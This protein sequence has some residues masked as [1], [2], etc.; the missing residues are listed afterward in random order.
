[1]IGAGDRWG[2]DHSKVYVGETL[3]LER[4]ILYVA[5]FTLRLHKFHRGDDDRASHTHPWWFITFPLSPYRE[6]VFRCGM[7]LGLRVVRAW[8]PHFRPADFE[9]I[10]EGG[11][12]W[13]EDDRTM[14]WS[15]HDRSF[16]TLV[17]TGRKR[18]AWGFYPKRGV[19]VPWR[20][21]T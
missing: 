6:R 7:S 15:R 1:M 17:L 19:F 18:S 8:R 13:I 10:V 11:V 5:G 12:D 3:Y 4:W 2:F 21:W 16:Y 14:H 9:H 20:K